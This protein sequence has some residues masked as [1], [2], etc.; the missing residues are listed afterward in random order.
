M[1]I[2]FT[3]VFAL[4]EF[5][6]NTNINEMQF[7]KKIA[8]SNITIIIRDMK[9]AR[10]STTTDI[11]HGPSFKIKGK[12]HNK[13]GDPICFADNGQPIFIY[14]G[15]NPLDKDEEKYLRNFINHNYLNLYNYWYATRDC[16]TQEFAKELQHE[17]QRRIQTNINHI[18]YSK[19]DYTYDTKVEISPKVQQRLNVSTRTI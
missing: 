8:K 10:G 1:G 16:E 15:N 13:D 3:E 5:E 4:V 14:K 2:Y 17:I 6:E 18:D 12:G 9:I 19:G 11:N 7:D